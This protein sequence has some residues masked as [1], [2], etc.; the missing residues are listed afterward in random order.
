PHDGHAGGRKDQGRR[1]HPRARD[2]R[3]EQV[4]ARRPETMASERIET[5][6]TGDRSGRHRD[7]GRHAMNRFIFSGI[8]VTA[9]AG[10]ACASDPGHPKTFST[11]WLD[12]QGKS[13]SDVQARLRGARPG[14][15]ADLV[16]AVAGSNDK[17]LGLPLGGG[18][19]WT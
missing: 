15:S 17:I 2:D 7:V 13:I 8:L 10:A 12:D 4:P 14:A 11:D 18:A 5:R 1:S 19:P 6:A 9:L 3:G 16:V